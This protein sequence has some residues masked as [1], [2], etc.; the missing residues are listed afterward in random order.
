VHGVDEVVIPG[1]DSPGLV[2]AVHHSFTPHAVL[3]WGEPYDSPL[4]LDREE[5]K[6]YVCRSYACQL[7]TD[8]PDIL[9]TQLDAKNP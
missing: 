2:A 5:G 4:W 8:D 1:D 7:P 3:A 6:S 9:I